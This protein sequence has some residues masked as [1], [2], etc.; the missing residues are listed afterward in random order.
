[1][2][3]IEWVEKIKQIIEKNPRT[4][5]KEV[6]DILGVTRQY[7]NWLKIK[8][9]LSFF[10]PAAVPCCICGKKAVVPSLELCGYHYNTFKHP[11]SPKFRYD[12]CLIC[13]KTPSPYRILG[14]CGSCYRKCKYHS[15]TKFRDKQRIY[16]KDHKERVRLYHQ[17]YKQK[18]QERVRERNRE[19]YLKHRQWHLDYQRN[20]YLTHRNKQLERANE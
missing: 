11:P 18:H 13:D 1:M 5:Q 6:A 19:N 12:T 8:Y 17:R 15:D 4:S 7:I 2:K 9:N 3:A 10:K 14:L 16:Q 20:Y